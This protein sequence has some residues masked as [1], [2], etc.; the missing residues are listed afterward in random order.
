MPDKLYVMEPYCVCLFSVT[1]SVLNL[2][3]PFR[4][5][6]LRCEAV[7]L[8][9]CFADEETSPDFPSQVVRTVDND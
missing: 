2:L 1:F 3:Q 7:K 6:L 9:K 8:Q 4:R 5:T